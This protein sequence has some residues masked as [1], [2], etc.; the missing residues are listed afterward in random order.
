MTWSFGVRYSTL[1]AEGEPDTCTRAGLGRFRR[2]VE[3]P[4]MAAGPLSEVMALGAIKGFCRFFVS[5]LSC[6]D[7][8]G[9]Q[10]DPEKGDSDK[11]RETWLCRPACVHCGCSL[12]L[13]CPTA[14]AV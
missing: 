8:R 7:A 3:G 14:V 1:Q 4:D 2:C 9:W 5:F 11:V 6:A 10:P 12:L 13:P